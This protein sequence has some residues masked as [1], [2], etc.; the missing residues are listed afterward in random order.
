MKPRW[1]IHR[2]LRNTVDSAQEHLSERAFRLFG[3]TLTLGHLTSSLSRGQ[4]VALHQIR[5]LRLLLTHAEAR[6][7][8]LEWMDGA[9]LDDAELRVRPPLRLRP[10]VQHL[11]PPR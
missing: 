7:A 3:I 6:L 4:G 11:A 10:A 2:E 9:H 8:R 5:R 1:L